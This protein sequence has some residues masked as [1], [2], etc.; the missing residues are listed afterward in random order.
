[1]A[2][3]TKRNSTS[4]SS[5]T[6]PPTSPNQTSLQSD[7]PTQKVT[8][9]VNET[10]PASLQSAPPVITTGPIRQ[11]SKDGAS[12]AT[13]ANWL[14]HIHSKTASD[15]S[16]PARWGGITEAIL[17]RPGVSILDEGGLNPD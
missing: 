8:P 17:S 9:H 10:S 13:A 15:C 16:T 4:L 2:H 7:T 11:A 3:Y 5:Y 6:P 12:P 14:F 1:M